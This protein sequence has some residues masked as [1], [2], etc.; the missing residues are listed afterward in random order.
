MAASLSLKAMS[1]R[2]SKGYYIHFRADNG[3]LFPFAIGQLAIK[4]HNSNINPKKGGKAVAPRSFPNM[5]VL[6][7]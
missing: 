7:V 6:L 2:G 4:E 5:T 3:E 1:L